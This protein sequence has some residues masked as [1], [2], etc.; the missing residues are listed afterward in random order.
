MK[1]MNRTIQD[2]QK[3]MNRKKIKNENNERK[4]KMQIIKMNMDTDSNHFAF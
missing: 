1:I 4:N 2:L 3:K